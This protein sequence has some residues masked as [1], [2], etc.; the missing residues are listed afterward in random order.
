MAENAD[1]TNR[2]HDDRSES[3]EIEEKT[4]RIVPPDEGRP[5]AEGPDVHLNVPEL[6]VDEISLEVNDLEAHVS[7]VAEVLDLLK[8]NVGADVGL[9]RVK[10]EIKGVAAQALLQVRLDNVAEIVDR[11]LTTLDRN[12][13]ILQHLGRGVEAIARDVGSGT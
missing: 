9:G 11:V 10:L 12:P 3:G 7:L 1:G 6:K 8:L 4:G 13:E 2:E 5:S